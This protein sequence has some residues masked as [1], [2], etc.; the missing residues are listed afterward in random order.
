V[1]P[2]RSRRAGQGLRPLLDR[3]EAAHAGLVP[4]DHNR[5]FCGMYLRNTRSLDAEL[6]RGGFRDPEWFGALTCVFA[7][8][9]LDALA[10]WQGGRP[11][12]RPWQLAFGARPDARP[13]RHLLVGLNAHLNADL[14]RALLAV[15]DDHDFDDETV[16]ALRRA[17]FH[18]VDGLVARRVPEEYRY[19][20]SVGG[21]AREQ[22]LM[23]LLYPLN[24]VTSR[25]WLV[26]SRRSV[27]RNAVELSCARRA[28]GQT[29]AERLAELEVLAA[30]RVADL[31]RP[32]NVLLRLAVTGFGVELPPSPPRRR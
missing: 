6:G 10:D 25:R 3:F 13:L 2:A 21:P 9:Y 27:W 26:A 30:T 23:R 1:T 32:G 31:I 29:L 16:L 14:P 4:D 15:M 8:L 7:D 22:A 12:T 19:L 20:R 5:H 11:V 17:D 18:H 28:G 24:L